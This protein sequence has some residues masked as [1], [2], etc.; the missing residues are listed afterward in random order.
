[1]DNAK[2]LC[3]NFVPANEQTTDLYIYDDIA[4]QRSYDPWTGEKGNEV[5]AKQF[6]E[7]LKK[8]ST[9]NIMV[10]INSAGGEATEGVAIGQ[11]I[12]DARAAGKKIDCKVD[13]MCASSAVNIAIACETVYIPNNAYMMIHDAAAWLHGYYM[14]AEM[15]LKIKQLDTLKKG[16]VAGYVEKTGLNEREIS[17]MMAATTW[18]TGAEA[19]EKGFAD[20]LL[21]EEIHMEI[22]K[23]TMTNS[24]KVNGAVFNSAI[25]DKAPK[26]LKEKT[27]QK[28]ENQMQEIKTKEELEKAYPELVEEIRKEAMEEGAEQERDRMKSIDDVANAVSEEE[29]KKA[30]YENLMTGKDLLFN[31]A[32][33]GALVNRAGAAVLAGMAKDAQAANGVGGFANSGANT[34]PMSEEQK[35]KMEA[36]KRAKKA[37]AQLCKKK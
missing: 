32:R 18:M 31:A 20:V 13:G 29:V 1:M 24:V 8:V 16:I 35:E 17:R 27:K 6:M 30:K 37:F 12:K 3:W 9:P 25:F 21:D 19:V 36:E 11:S 23:D 22:Q 4:S 33:N 5:S 28:G 15:A 14:A 26:A 34:T 7:Q 10:H 2:R